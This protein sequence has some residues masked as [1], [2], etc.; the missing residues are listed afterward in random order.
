MQG[1]LAL[2]LAYEYRPDV[3]L[4]DLHLP[5]MSGSQVLDRLRANP[6]IGGI[7]VVIISA[8][9]TTRQFERLQAA[10]AR[11]YLTKPLD[12]KHFL[13]VLDDILYDR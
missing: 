9:A 2:D 13:K 5:D 11:D 12:V 4:L 8:D 10:G 3:I 6:Q 1:G 7:P